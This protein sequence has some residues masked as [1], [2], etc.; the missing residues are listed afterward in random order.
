M[1][2]ARTAYKRDALV[3]SRRA[4]TAHRD[5]RPTSDEVQRHALV[6]ARRGDEEGR[7]ALAV[8]DLQ[9]RAAFLHQSARGVDPAGAAGPV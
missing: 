7:L 1:S 6:P 3:S 5:V 2:T 8:A 9:L 4:G